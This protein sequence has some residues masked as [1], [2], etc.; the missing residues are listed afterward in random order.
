MVIKDLL[1]IVSKE[2]SKREQA[3][4]MKKFFAGM[5]IVVALGASAAAAVLLTAESGKKLQINMRKNAENLV[6]TIRDTV[7]RKVEKAKNGAAHAADDA[8]LTIEDMGGEL[9]AVKAEMKDGSREVKQDLHET[10]KNISKELSG[11]VK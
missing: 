8:C 7:Q 9:D 1:D 10:A 11:A 5:G 6:E 4:A 3:K 2:K